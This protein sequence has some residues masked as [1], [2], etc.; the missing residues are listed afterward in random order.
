MRLPRVIGEAISGG[1]G[2]TRAVRVFSAERKPLIF[3]IKGEN[4]QGKINT[5]VLAQVKG[6]ICHTGL[7]SCTERNIAAAFF[8]PPA[9]TALP[10]VDKASHDWRSFVS[11][12]LCVSAF[13]PFHAVP[14]L[15]LL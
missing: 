15:C 2:N 7:N 3:E 1:G 9:N 12:G 14:P 5:D 6:L 4:K 10:A 8:S 11:S 13:I